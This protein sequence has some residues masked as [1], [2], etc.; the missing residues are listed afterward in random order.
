MIGF[1]TWDLG[2]IFF[3][4]V[5]GTVGVLYIL[6]H[7][8]Y[9]FKSTHNL[10]T[11]SFFFLFSLKQNKRFLSRVPLHS[12][13]RTTGASTKTLSATESITVEITQTNLQKSVPNAVSNKLFIYSL[14]IRHVPS[15]SEENIS[16]QFAFLLV[17]VPWRSQSFFFD[18]CLSKL[19]QINAFVFLDFIWP[20]N[21]EVSKSSYLILCVSK[22][23][24]VSFWV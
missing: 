8:Y 16:P 11:L 21:V 12:V 2:R 10:K 6:N 13:V 14:S 5:E 22:G 19:S 15:G 20:V 9:I 17:F 23:S 1:N 7:M 3:P 24:A 18:T 4:S